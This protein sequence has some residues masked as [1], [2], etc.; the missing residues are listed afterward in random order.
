MFLLSSVLK[1]WKVFL[2]DSQKRGYGKELLLCSNTFLDT[3]KWIL[4]AERKTNK[5]GFYMYVGEDK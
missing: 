2:R 3:K 4:V 5:M 1:N